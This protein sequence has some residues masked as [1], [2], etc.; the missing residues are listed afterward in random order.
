MYLYSFH[1]ICLQK[2]NPLHL[3]QVQFF[4][5]YVTDMLNTCMHVHRDNN[6]EYAIGSYYHYMKQVFKIEIKLS[7]IFSRQNFSQLYYDLSIILW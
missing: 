6:Y 3:M 2:E 5:L 4:F 1:I 7:H